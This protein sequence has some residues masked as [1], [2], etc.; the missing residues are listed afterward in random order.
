MQ[1]VILSGEITL[2]YETRERERGGERERERV[3]CPGEPQF[4]RN[5][6]VCVSKDRHAKML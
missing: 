5:R 6:V 2:D 3:D 1:W 4:T